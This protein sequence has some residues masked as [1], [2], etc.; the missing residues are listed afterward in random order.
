MYSLMGNTE[1][2]DIEELFDGLYRLD[3]AEYWLVSIV[4]RVRC[5]FSGTV[6]DT[7][8]LFCVIA[9]KGRMVCRG[10]KEPPDVGCC[11][12]LSDRVEA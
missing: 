8:Q 12:R 11:L 2:R 1:T 10:W 4:A 7:G 3:L 5:R 9:A 6:E